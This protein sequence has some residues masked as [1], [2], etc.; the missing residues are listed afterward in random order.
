MVLPHLRAGYIVLADRY[1]Y[2]AYA[3]DMA[4]GCNAQWV[5]NVYR[6]AVQPSISFYFQTPLEVSLERILSSRPELKYHEAGLDLGLAADPAESFKIFQGRIKTHYDEM[7]QR[8]HFR[9]ID[10]TR[11]VEA[12]QAVVRAAVAEALRNYTTPSM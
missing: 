1:I 12:Q 11:P 6:F 9:V 10:A 8:E 4:R 7:A 2:T 3:R 5:R